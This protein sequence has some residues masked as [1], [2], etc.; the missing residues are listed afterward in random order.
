MVLTIETSEVGPVQQGRVE[1][2]DGGD[3]EEQV[4]SVGGV[5]DGVGEQIHL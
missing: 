3:V 4:G 5:T 1:G 2:R